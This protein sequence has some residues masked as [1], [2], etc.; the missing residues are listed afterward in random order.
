MEFIKGFFITLLV[1]LVLIAAGFGLNYA[2][3]M[4]TAFFQPKYEQIRRN[5]FE[6]SQ[7]YNEGMIRD[8]ENIRN[9]YLAAN[10]PASKAA[11]RA[12]FIHRAEGYPNTLPS[13]LQSFYDNIRN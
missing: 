9:Q 3:L 6:Q 5:T 8:L 4:N 11:L 10:D 1:I 2:G 13:D 12:T 7:A